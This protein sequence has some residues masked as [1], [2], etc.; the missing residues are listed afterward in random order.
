LA[1]DFRSRY[2]IFE[3]KNY[4]GR[5]GQAEVYSTEKYLFTTALRSVAILIARSGWDAGA[6]RAAAGALRESGKLI[7]FV[8]LDELCEMLHAADRNEEPEIML[9]RKLD[10]LLTKMLR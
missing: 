8:S 3:F 5:I 10:D 4:S 2:L 7:L 6:S 9:Y 1:H